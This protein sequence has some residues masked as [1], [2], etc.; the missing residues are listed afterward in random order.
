MKLFSQ[1]IELQKKFF[2]YR[3]TADLVVSSIG[4]NKQSL[5]MTIRLMFVFKSGDLSIQLY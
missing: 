2:K 3:Y 5:G 4:D 1:K